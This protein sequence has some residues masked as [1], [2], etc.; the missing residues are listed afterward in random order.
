M[1]VERDIVLDLLTDAEGVQADQ[2]LGATLRG[3]AHFVVENG[4]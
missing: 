1:E 4:A 3:E 2:L